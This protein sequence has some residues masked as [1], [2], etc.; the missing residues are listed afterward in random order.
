[1]AGDEPVKDTTAPHTEAS[2]DPSVPNPA[3]EKVTE[4]ST[5]TTSQQDV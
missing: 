1:M 2:A 3:T 5:F 4:V